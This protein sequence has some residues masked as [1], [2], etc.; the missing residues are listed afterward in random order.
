[1][2][3]HLIPRAIED[4]VL[5]TRLIRVGFEEALDLRIIVDQN[6]SADERFVMRGND[7]AIRGKSVE[8]ADDPLGLFGGAVMGFVDR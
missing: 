4:D 8:E 6:L 3:G 5:P 1:M 2:V 7:P